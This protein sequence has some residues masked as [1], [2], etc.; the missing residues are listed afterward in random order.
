M[1]RI[2]C[3]LS[4]S[5]PL[6]QR[7]LIR[8]VSVI[9]AGAFVVATSSSPVAARP[10]VAAIYGP[11]STS[12]HVPS[13]VSS[14]D[15]CNDS[16]AS[17]IVVEICEKISASTDGYTPQIVHDLNQ[18]SG[19]DVQIHVVPTGG[20]YRIVA[21]NPGGVRYKELDGQ[22]PAM[23]KNW[24]GSDL[25]ALLP[26]SNDAYGADIGQSPADTTVLQI[27]AF[28]FGAS[29]GAGNAMNQALM[30]LLGLRGVRAIGSTQ[31]AEDVMKSGC[32]TKQTYLLYFLST[33]HRDRAAIGFARD[34][35]SATGFLYTCDQHTVTP[36]VTGTDSAKYLKSADKTA[37]LGLTAM[38]FPKL[39]WSAV[40]P[41]AA[42]SLSLMNDPDSQ[43]V[44]ST[45]SETR[46]MQ[47]MVDEL[48]ATQSLI[49]CNGRTISDCSHAPSDAL[50]GSLFYDPRQ[51]PNCHV[52]PP[53]P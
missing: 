24:G 30:T 18:W 14:V 35:S 16:A 43:D 33:V 32:T 44:I 26:G 48:C 1:L 40:N 19:A 52:I 4:A 45:D 10:A 11:T 12:S 22:T 46:A 25:S 7:R 15:A 29:G 34:D 23:V 21:T 8:A 36:A 9:T 20:T 17:Q 5:R 28:S 50:L 53:D 31:S 2:F 27:A 49:A 3:G 41:A 6:L 39:A 37:L 51:P 42:L 13:R 38:L 47:K